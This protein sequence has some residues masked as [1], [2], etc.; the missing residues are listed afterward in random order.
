MVLFLPKVHQGVFYDRRHAFA[1]LCGMRDDVKLRKLFT[2]DF[3]EEAAK[4]PRFCTEL[5]DASLYDFAMS[6][7]T[8]AFEE[9]LSTR[10]MAKLRLVY[11]NPTVPSPYSRLEDD[12]G[13]GENGEK[14]MRWFKEVRKS[15]PRMKKSSNEELESA[16][17]SKNAWVRLFALKEIVTRSWNDTFASLAVLL[18]KFSQDPND[19]IAAYA[20]RISTRLA[21]EGRPSGGGDKR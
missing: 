14:W 7:K 21:E 16:L 3:L 13:F 15:L 18:R 8:W 11:G 17:D 19:S 10:K 5:L 4:N 6:G 1:M 12:W 2:T 20:K 9:F